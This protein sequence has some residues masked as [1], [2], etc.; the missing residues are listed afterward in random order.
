[1]VLATGCRAYLPSSSRQL[2]QHSEAAATG[3]FH[4]ALAVEQELLQQRT[5]LRTVQ[6][7]SNAGLQPKYYGV[8][9][10]S[11][12]ICPHGTD[13][14]FSQCEKIGVLT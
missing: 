4:N 5:T 2:F 13:C 6:V 7:R 14:S 12:G 1:M 10:Q 3:F 9:D 11:S 8:V